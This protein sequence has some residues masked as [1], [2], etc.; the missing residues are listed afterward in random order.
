[1]KKIPE[2]MIIIGGGVI[3]C[4][5]A[6]ILNSFGSKVT[7]IEAMPRLIHEC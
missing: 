4:E 6:H 5:F 1:M 3:G 2:S 7:V